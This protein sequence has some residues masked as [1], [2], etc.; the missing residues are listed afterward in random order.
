MALWYGGE[1]TVRETTPGLNGIWVADERLTPNS[2]GDF[3]KSCL[4]SDKRPIKL[5]LGSKVAFFTGKPIIFVKREHVAYSH[6]QFLA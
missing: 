1:V 6:F 4:N 3:G 2:F 5:L